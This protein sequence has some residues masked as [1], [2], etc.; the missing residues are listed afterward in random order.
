[1]HN[2]FLGKVSLHQDKII[3]RLNFWKL[4]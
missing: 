2:E 3:I 4:F 1:M